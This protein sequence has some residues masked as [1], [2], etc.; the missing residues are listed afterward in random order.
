MK[1]ATYKILRAALS[2]DDTIAPGQRDTALSI[3]NGRIAENGPLPLL[4][5]QK[6]ASHLLGVSRFTIWRMTQD[7]ELHPVRLHGTYRYRRA[8]IEKVADGPA[9]DTCSAEIG[10]KKA[11]N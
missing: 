4:L 7:G 2:A 9:T 10:E 8:E 1:S 5:T 6:Q 3:L 11:A